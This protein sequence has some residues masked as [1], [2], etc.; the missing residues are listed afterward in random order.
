LNFLHIGASVLS[1]Y[2]HRGN[3]ERRREE[4]IEEDEHEKNPN[5]AVAPEFDVGEGGLQ[6]PEESSP[7][8]NEEYEAK[9]YSCLLAPEALLRNPLRE[10]GHRTLERPWDSP[11]RF[12][13]HRNTVA[14]P[15]PDPLRTSALKIR[16]AEIG[17]L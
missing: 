11:G 16:L 12:E 4:E 15:P 9:P 5:A 3:S 8:P 6:T 17:V 13:G 2:L 7:L 1:A 14:H 10:R